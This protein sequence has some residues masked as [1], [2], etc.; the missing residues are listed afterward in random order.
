MPNATRVAFSKA[1]T[2]TYACLLHE[3]MAGTV[4][5]AP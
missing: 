2:Y 1:G 5:V 4:V 3:G